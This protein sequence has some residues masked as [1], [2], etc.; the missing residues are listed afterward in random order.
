MKSCSLETV[1]ETVPS[2][3]MQPPVTTCNKSKWSG[4]IFY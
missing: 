2:N 1:C 4:Y 3:H